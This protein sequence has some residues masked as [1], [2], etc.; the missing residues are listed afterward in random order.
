MVKR[1]SIVLVIIGACIAAYAEEEKVGEGNFLSNTI[2]SV[3][4]KVGKYTSGEK[5][6]IP[7]DRDSWNSEEKAYEADPLDK[8]M[9]K[10]VTIRTGP[11][12][13]PALDK[14]Q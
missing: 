7:L 13:A 10:N 5:K 6:L 9:S 2:T 8:K 14:K 4:D 12:Q 11:A 1:M 3:F